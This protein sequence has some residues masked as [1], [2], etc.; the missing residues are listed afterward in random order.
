[1]HLRK[2]DMSYADMACRLIEEKSP[3]TSVDFVVAAASV[4][5]DIPILMVRPTQHKVLETGRVYYEFH[6]IRPLQSEQYLPAHKHKIFLMFNGVDTFVPFMKT[7][8]ASVL[9]V[10]VSAMRQVVDAYTSVKEVLKE[11]PNKTVLKNALSDILDQLKSATKIG[12]KTKFT[13]GDVIDYPE[14]KTVG[15]ASANVNVRKR[16]TDSASNSV[17]PKKRR[18]EKSNSVQPHESNKTSEQEEENAEAPSVSKNCERKPNQCHCG[19]NFDNPGDYNAHLN[20]KHQ[21]ELWMCSADNCREICGKRSTLWAHYRRKHENRFHNY[22]GI[23]KC[24]YGSDEAW[25]VIKHKYTDHQIP[26]P[27]ANKCPRCEKPFGQKV[28]LA[29]H[30]VICKTD[31]HPF[32]CETCNKKFRQKETLVRH[33]RQEHPKGGG[34]NTDKYYFICHVCGTKYKSRSGLGQHKCLGPLSDDSQ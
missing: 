24:T 11:I 7:E 4:M 17:D 30:L 16:K 14:K 1:M 23:G 32:I 22:C 31:D 34:E 19:V 29:R 25:S 10:G 18:T 8:I 27:E 15:E 28:K 21:N 26:I 20:S 2:M 12:A 13:C 5:L 9:N 3:G 33:K 6:E